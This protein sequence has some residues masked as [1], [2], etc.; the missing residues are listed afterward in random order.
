MQPNGHLDPGWTT[1]DPGFEDRRG[2]GPKARV[3]RRFEW[4][5]SQG[6]A[7][8]KM[9]SGDL[10]EASPTSNSNDCLYTSVIF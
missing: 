8:S 1:A 6:I 10:Y 5:V 7:G 4:S 9:F 2:R 3:W